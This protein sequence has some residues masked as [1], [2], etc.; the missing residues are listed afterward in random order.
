MQKLC[1]LKQTMP[2]KIRGRHFSVLLPIIL[3]C[4]LSDDLT[5]LHISQH[6][7]AI[8]QLLQNSS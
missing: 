1:W 2:S 7:N 6:T 3:F 4:Q 8:Q 5:A